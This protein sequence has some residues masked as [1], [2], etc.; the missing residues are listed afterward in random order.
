MLN[1]LEQIGNVSLLDY[2]YDISYKI[3]SENGKNITFFDDSYVWVRLRTNYYFDGKF[4]RSSN[5][6]KPTRC[7]ETKS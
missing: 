6:E 4:S 1:N 3:Y 2:N 5:Y 7:S